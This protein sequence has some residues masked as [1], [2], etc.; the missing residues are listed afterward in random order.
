[1]SSSSSVVY[2][3]LLATAATALL[4]AGCG[5]GVSP[6]AKVRAA[7]ERGEAAAEAG[8]ATAL[9]R[10][11]HPEY[12]DEHGLDRL[13]LRY[14]VRAWLGQHPGLSIQILSR[15]LQ[16]RP[17]EVLA[18]LQMLVDGSST[19]VILT[20]REDDGEWKVARARYTA[21]GGF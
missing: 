19:R 18:T 21:P 8:D 1:M 2:Q 6:E 17:D 11:V 3:A 13:R 15:D 10:L 14:A 5:D 12:R 20:F 7:I 16:S 4:L 9:L